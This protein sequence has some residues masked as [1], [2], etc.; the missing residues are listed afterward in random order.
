MQSSEAQLK[1]L[2][3]R[4]IAVVD[5]ARLATVGD[6]DHYGAL[7]YFVDQLES[8]RA[9]YN[10]LDWP[11]ANEPV[12][13][14]VD[15]FSESSKGSDLAI[16]KLVEFWKLR[17]TSYPQWVTMPEDRRRHLWAQVETETNYLSVWPSRDGVM[18]DLPL[19][20]AYEFLWLLERCLCPIPS[21]Y[22]EFLEAEFVDL[23]AA[24]TRFSSDGKR[25]DG[26]ANADRTRAGCHY[27]LL[28]MM[29]HY[30]EQRRMEEWSRV[31]KALD[32]DRGALSPEHRAR[33]HYERAL[34]AIFSLS[35]EGLER[36]LAEWLRNEALPFWEAKRAVLLMEIG[37]DDEATGILESSL[38]KV[39]SRSNLKPTTRHYAA[40]SQ[41]AIL[42]QML[43][44]VVQRQMRRARHRD[45][46]LA[47][48]MKEFTEREQALRQYKCDPGTEIDIM[49]RA[50]ERRSD[51][52]TVTERLEFDL[53]KRTIVVDGELWREE[54]LA[55]W[56]WVRFWEDSGVGPWVG[57]R[58]AAGLMTRLSGELPKWTLIA[59]LARMGREEGCDHVLGRAAVAQMA[60]A[61]V[62]DLAGQIL[63]VLRGAVEV[64]RRGGRGMLVEGMINVLPEVLS[65]LCCRCSVELLQ[66]LMG[67]VVDQYGSRGRG[68]IE[69]MGRLAAR[70]LRGLGA[71]ERSGWLPKL[72]GIAVPHEGDEWDEEQ[73]PNPLGLLDASEVVS[74]EV[75]L[76][77]R[78]VR[79]VV[80]EVSS[81][82]G[83]ARRWA[84]ETVGKLSE[85]KVLEP[86][87][88]EEFRK[89]LWH[90]VGEDGFP[91][92]V[93]WPRS[94][95][96]SMVRPAGG[97]TERCFKRYLRTE[98]GGGEEWG[99]RDLD[100]RGWCDE[101]RG[102]SEVEWSEEDVEFVADRV[103]GWW[104]RDRERLRQG[105]G[106]RAVL[107]MWEDGHYRGLFGGCVDAVCAMIEPG[108]SA[109]LSE[110]ARGELVSWTRELRDYGVPALRLEAALHCT[111][112]GGATDLWARLRGAVSAAE[113][114]RVVDGLKACLFLA[115]G[116]GPPE[117]GGSDA[118]RKELLEVLALACSIVRLRR[119]TS[120]A[121]IVEGMAEVVRGREWILIGGTRNVLLE[122]LDK[123]VEDT[124]FG[125]GGT[126]GVERDEDV[127]RKLTL[128]RAGARLA[129]VMAGQGDEGDRGDS[130]GV[131]ERWRAVCCSREEFT[132]V[133]NEWG[134]G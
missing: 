50:L 82:D 40:I 1:L 109:C 17:R 116:I 11:R 124:A 15:L 2:E 121:V 92:G 12:A 74:G 122:G 62:D 44:P 57:L 34:N 66:R 117:G 119:E 24:V 79:V 38:S 87:L 19:A 123:I 71:R 88:E 108:G 65:R 129:R 95:F 105:E 37:K 67:F 85:L 112:G 30:R 93:K 80:G 69:G 103:W 52:R 59:L 63:D 89:A 54:V 18:I 84:I 96:M 97:A 41:E 102:A 99:E 68:R 51:R 131:I 128:R 73:Y 6:D 48:R 4:N 132:E 55:A 110:K 76:D 120:V 81:E 75:D 53:G 31:A 86:E 98:V 78:R 83:V 33:L 113:E 114:E 23:N 127:V 61:E 9:D 42:M 70:V 10:A 28:V 7:E 29:R 60:S 90:R 111:A 5:L 46:T 125:Q 45:S 104:E 130:A 64:R 43:R 118:E 134:E 126:S 25:V 13:P 107:P 26:F 39:R 58:G 3:R 36:E 14:Q 16:A 20:F 115:E 21:Q 100:E 77:E 72:V 35:V 22:M 91:V 101:I 27:V 8:R 106:G 49:A 56:N 47:D 133:R 32:A 94:A